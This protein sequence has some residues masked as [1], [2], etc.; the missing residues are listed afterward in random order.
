M[1]QNTQDANIKLI[2]KLVFVVIGMF[3]FGFALVPLY[4]IL[5]EVTGLNG[6]TNTVAASAEN[7]SVNKDR[8]ITVEFIA[9]TNKGIPWDF[10][11]V[12]K[13]I[14]V[15]PGEVKLVNYF[16]KNNSINDIVGQAVPSVAPSQA[17]SYF[18]KIE[19][20]C[21]NHQP[22]GGGEE[23]LMPLTFYIDED[24][25]RDI[26]TLTLSYTLYDVTEAVGASQSSQTGE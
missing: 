23:T 16:A 25:P 17:A 3:G 2:K 10:G 8:V 5:C 18:N 22:L 12:E 6:K 7:I 9:T 21:F 14:Q 24:L 4:D 19:C 26:N 13:K 11:P 15:H 1:Q 20:F